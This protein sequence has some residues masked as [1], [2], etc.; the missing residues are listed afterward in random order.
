[1]DDNL[2]QIR[3][4][5]RFAFGRNW[6]AFAN[7]VDERRIQHAIGSL[8]EALDVEHL[9]GRTFLDVGCGSGLFSLAAHRLGARVHSFD[10]DAEAVESASRLRHAFAPDASWTIEQGSI[11]DGDHLARLG[12]FDVVYIWGV[13]HHTGDMWQA[14]DNAVELVAPG[15]LLFVSLYNDQGWESRI[16]TVVKR[17]YNRSGPVTRGALIA[18]SSAYIHRAWPLLHIGRLL[19]GRPRPAAVRPRGMSRWHDMLDWVGGYPFEVSKPEQ[20]LARARTHDLSLMRLRTCGGG[21]GCNQYLLR[22]PGGSAAAQEPADSTD[23]LAHLSGTRAQAPQGHS[24]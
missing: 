8:R 19:T 5:D 14:F 24:R 2:L 9:A 4:G 7:L 17:R 11:L 18:G 3:R 23:D 13:L 20:V 21:L 12:T 10:F 15:G 16:W 22:R 6:K 1:M